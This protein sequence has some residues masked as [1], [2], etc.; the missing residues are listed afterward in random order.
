MRNLGTLWATLSAGRR[1]GAG[2]GN[3]KTPRRV[4]KML[5]RGGNNQYVPASSLHRMSRCGTQRTQRVILIRLP[6]GIAGSAEKS[7]RRRSGENERDIY[8]GKPTGQLPPPGFSER[9]KQVKGKEVWLLV[10]ELLFSCRPSSTCTRGF[11]TPRLPRPS[12]F[13]PG[14]VFD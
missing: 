6:G 8:S 11:S 2:W 9:R 3:E 12:P 5:C 4:R 1:G 7:T 10:D 14:A 13:K